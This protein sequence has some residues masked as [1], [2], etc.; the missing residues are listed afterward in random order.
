MTAE[1]ERQVRK[2]FFPPKCTADITKNYKKLLTCEYRNK[3][4]P[5]SKHFY[6][7]IVNLYYLYVCI[8]EV[9]KSYS[10]FLTTSIH[11]TMQLLC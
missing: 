6:V 11:C 5:N 9:F 8:S 3:V 2:G 7:A 10:F 4:Q 1:G